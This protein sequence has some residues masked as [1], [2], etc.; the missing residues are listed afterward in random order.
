[1]VLLFVFVN[2]ISHYLLLTNALKKSIGL[3]GLPES[4]VWA[5]NKRA[6]LR[7]TITTVLV[8]ITVESRSCQ[9]GISVAASREIMVMGE[10]KGIRLKARNSGLLGAAATLLLKKTGIMRG[11]ITRIVA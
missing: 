5:R 4:S 1:M 2:G 9:R 8:R 3:N 6:T 10:V 11:K 7:N